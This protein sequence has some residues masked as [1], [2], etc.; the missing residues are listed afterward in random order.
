[1]KAMI[2]A[3]GKGTRVRPITYMIPKPMIPILH[4][5]V[6]EF[7][8]E[9]LRRHGFDQIMI[10][11][12]H[13]AD[14]IEDYFR[15]GQQWG[16]HIGFSFEGYFEDGKPVAQAIGSAGGLKKIQDFSGFFDDT[17]VVLCGDALI[18]LNI[19][20]VLRYHWRKGAMATVVLRRMEPDL[21]SNYG[22]VVTDEEGRIL[23]FQE[24]PAQADA[25]SNLTNT[26]IYIFE[27]EIFDY[28]PSGQSFDIGGDLFPDL[29]KAGVPFYGMEADFQWVDIGR[30]PDYYEAIHKIL[31]GEVT[32][33]GIPGRQVAPG[34]WT[35]INLK[36]NWDR[37]NITPPVYIGSSSQ[38]ADGVKI[39]GPTSIGMGCVLNEGCV[40]DQS[41]IFNYTQIARGV[42]LRQQM[43]LGKY[44]ISSDGETIDTE[45][46]D[47]SWLIGDARR[48]PA[49]PIQ[50]LIAR[51]M[52][53]L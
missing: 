22:V 46:T 23:T 47:L 17:F 5:P 49:S 18:D 6:M 52:T 12:S 34:I 37:V 21:V 15:D 43:V 1:M 42:T 41:V 8:V 14:Q 16:V 2:L 39:I 33:V 50:P 32:G 53:S 27:P 30:T 20:E 3:A 38:I 26:G 35:G 19:T 29:V 4:K 25:L 40:V 48:T 24:K 45:E 36:M 13:L 28:I 11:T 10:N 44:C 51:R 9:L 31:K 7:L